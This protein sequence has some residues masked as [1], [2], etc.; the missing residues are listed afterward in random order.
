MSQIR[1]IRYPPKLLCQHHG[2]CHTNT[3]LVSK[4]RGFVWFCRYL[5]T[6]VSDSSTKYLLLNDKNILCLRSIRLPVPVTSRSWFLEMQAELKDPIL[7]QARHFCF[8]PMHAEA[9]ARC[10]GEPHRKQCSK[11]AALL[12][13]RFRRLIEHVF[14]CFV[15]SFTWCTPFEAQAI[16]RAS[17]CACP[18]S[19]VWK[20]SLI[21]GQTWNK[22]QE[23]RNVHEV[24][25]RCVLNLLISDQFVNSVAEVAR[26]S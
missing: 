6:P 21:Q 26:S 3:G 5:S 24:G 9:F 18:T 1:T 13:G 8:R 4:F 11:D 25:G 7:G 15:T 10:F 23:T 20:T 14:F 17:R 16:A 19:L 12:A 22:K 2:Q